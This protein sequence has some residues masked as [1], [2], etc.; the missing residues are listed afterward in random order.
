MRRSAPAMSPGQ[1]EYT[2]RRFFRY[3]PVVMFAL[4]FLAA[5]GFQLSC[6]SSN[7]EAASRQA[8]VYS[9]NPKSMKFH[10]PGCRYYNCKACVK[11]FNSME[12]AEAQ[13]YVAC[14]RCRGVPSVR[15]APVPPHY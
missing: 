11:R 4:F 1:A 14:K 15:Y 3:L 9:G 6:V 8:V 12:E 10:A 13:G 2:H 7:A 5:V